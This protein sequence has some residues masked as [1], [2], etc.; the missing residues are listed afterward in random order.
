MADRMPAQ[1]NYFG[2][3]TSGIARRVVASLLVVLFS[4][5]ICSAQKISDSGYKAVGYIKADGTIQDSN[6]RTIGHVKSDGTVQDASYRTIGHVYNIPM[7]W[8]ALFFFFIP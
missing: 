1:K 5:G 4:F 6:Y 3:M 2:M 8:A 7:E